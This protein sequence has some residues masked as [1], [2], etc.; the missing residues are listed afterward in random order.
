MGR[1]FS[2]AFHDATGDTRSGALGGGERKSD[3]EEEEEAKGEVERG[4]DEGVNEEKGGVHRNV[5]E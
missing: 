1:S 4:N 3:G 2:I 5:V